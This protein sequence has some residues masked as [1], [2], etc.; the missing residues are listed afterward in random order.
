MTSDS[1]IQSQ[2]DEMESLLGQMIPLHE[3][4]LSCATDKRE[5]VRAAD[6]PRVPEICDR[7]R[8][9]LQRVE[10][11]ELGRRAIVDSLAVQINGKETPSLHALAALAETPQCERLTVLGTRLRDL[12]HAVRQESTIVRAAVEALHRHM[13]GVVQTVSAAISQARVYSASGRMRVDAPFESCLD[14]TS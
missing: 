3:Q 4:L 5:A 1:S 7:E 10:R 9:L 12:S 13:T 6:I 14:V 11:M 2:L 8:A